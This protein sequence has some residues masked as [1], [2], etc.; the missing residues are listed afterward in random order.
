MADTALADDAQ[1]SES[2]ESRWKRT[3]RVCDLL[4]E[5]IAILERRV[6]ELNQQLGRHE[7]LLC[8]QGDD[9]LRQDVSAESVCTGCGDVCQ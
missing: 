2:Y 7:C 6:N 9:T 3:S 8:E 4:R 5:R 1:P